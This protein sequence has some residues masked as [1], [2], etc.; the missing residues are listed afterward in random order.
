MPLTVS[1]CCPAYDTSCSN[2]SQPIRQ[3]CGL[4]R[5]YAL[6]FT[7]SQ[8]NEFLKFARFLANWW[9]FACNRSPSRK[10]CSRINPS[11]RLLSRTPQSQLQQIFEVNSNLTPTLK[12]IIPQSGGLSS[13]KYQMVSTMIT[14]P[15]IVFSQL[16]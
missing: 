5:R 1:A 13:P 9:Y 2:S 16:K 12:P 3:Y 6:S 15:L 8:F 14:F 10:L 4:P 7:Q 11:K